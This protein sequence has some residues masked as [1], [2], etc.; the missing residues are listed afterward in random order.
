MHLL[1]ICLANFPYLLPLPCFKYSVN[2][3][4]YRCATYTTS[5]ISVASIQLHFANKLP[6]GF[7]S[8][9]LVTAAAAAAAAATIPGGCDVRWRDLFPTQWLVSMTYLSERL[10]KSCHRVS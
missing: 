9:Q 7:P 10:T 1:G 3:H 5:G 6:A 8:I 4:K 2:L